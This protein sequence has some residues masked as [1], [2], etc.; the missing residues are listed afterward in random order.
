MRGG[1]TA[2]TKNKGKVQLMG[3]AMTSY[4]DIM[5][6]LPTNKQEREQHISYKEK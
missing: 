4:S 1:A 6:S 3:E 5:S 2:C